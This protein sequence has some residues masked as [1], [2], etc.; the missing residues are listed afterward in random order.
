LNQTAWVL[1]LT[2]SL[3]SYVILQFLHLLNK[4]K[5]RTCLIG[6]L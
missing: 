3:S 1:I 4:G 5:N 6:L 2:L